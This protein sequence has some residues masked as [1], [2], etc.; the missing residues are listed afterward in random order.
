MFMMSETFKYVYD[1]ADDAIFHRSNNGEV[2]LCA[3]MRR[4]IYLVLL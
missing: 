1:E 3:F 2:R 4:V